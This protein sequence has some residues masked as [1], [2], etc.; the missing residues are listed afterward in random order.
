MLTL[1]QPRQQLS[2]SSVDW[3][4]RGV[5][6][7]WRRRSI[8]WRRR[9]RSINRRR[10]WRSVHGR[11]GRSVHG[12]RR[13]GRRCVKWR[14]RGRGIHGRRR[15]CVQGRDRR[16][17]NR[18]HGNRERRNGKREWRNGRQTGAFL[19]TRRWLQTRTM[20]RDVVSNIDR[21]TCTRSNDSC[22][23]H[24]NAVTVQ[25]FNFGHH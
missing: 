17:G 7:R 9:R 23:K 12:R 10:R 16:E 25:A 11:R 5:D 13:R 8:D 1:I 6:W 15:G 19:I 3:R 18:R 14:R 24:H 22:Q 2:T 20:I 21:S 4:R